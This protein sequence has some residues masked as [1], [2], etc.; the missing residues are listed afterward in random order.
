MAQNRP[1]EVLMLTASSEEDAVIEAVAAARRSPSC[2]RAASRVPGGKV[3][4]GRRASDE[5]MSEERHTS[6]DI[7]GGGTG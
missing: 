5:G 2:C 3:S 6:E 4:T 7:E 1:F